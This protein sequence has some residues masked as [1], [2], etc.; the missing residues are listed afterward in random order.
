MT[1]R[2]PRARDLDRPLGLRELVV[3]HRSPL[4]PAM[5]RV[6]LGG[7]QLAGFES[8]LPD[9]HVKLV[10]P[11]PE[12]GHVRPPVLEGGRLRWPRPFPPGREYTVR[13]FDPLRGE[14]DIDVVL[15]GSG[16]GAD[17][18]RQAPPGS[19]IWVVGPR[20]ARIIPVEFGHHV[21]L[22]DETA[23]PAI[24]RWLESLPPS[25][26]AVA[27]I[28]VGGPDDEQDVSVPAGSTLTWLHRHGAP[29]GTTSL[30]AD[31]AETITLPT[32]THTFVFAA[33]EAETLKPVRA[34]A[35][36][37]GIGPDQSTISGYWRRG[38]AR[39]HST[40]LAGQVLHRLGHLI[41]R[42]R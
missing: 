34:W 31:F 18:A 24:T 22:G 36:R 25:A 12:T 35:R 28:E 4:T 8:H 42:H 41:G 16:L 37:H 14:L 2:P 19:T 6:T 30:L 27:A 9:E 10:F 13:R 20:P 21:L 38:T 40:S 1:N 26:R 29:A 3:L 11:D 5:M 33:G 32:G 23:L 39:H 15:H 17:W 7:P